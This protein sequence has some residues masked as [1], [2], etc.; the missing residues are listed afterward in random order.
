MKQIG[1]NSD[2]LWD[3]YDKERNLVGKLHRNKV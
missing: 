1:E 3:V 2:E